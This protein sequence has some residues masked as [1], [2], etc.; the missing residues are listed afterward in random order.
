MEMRA[1]PESNGGPDFTA[2]PDDQA[3]LSKL[4]RSGVTDAGIERLLSL[5]ACCQHQSLA[6][7]GLVTSPRLE[8]ARWLVDQGRLGE[9]RC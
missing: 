6:L 9:G 7:D 5:R 4:W 3:V 2:R 8:F 1:A